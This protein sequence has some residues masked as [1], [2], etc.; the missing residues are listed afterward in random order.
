MFLSQSEVIRIIE[1]AIINKKILKVKYQHT[2]SDNEI[3]TSIKAPF[4]LGTTNTKTYY[5][6]KDN[7]Y[8]FCF[9]HI[10]EKTKQKLPIVHPISSL[11]IMSIAETGQKF[12][13]IELTDI[14]KANNK[15]D[16]R[17]CKWSLIPN[18]NWYK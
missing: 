11:H 4:D 15:Y 12:D 13:P 14:N 7:L 18:R 8:M 17:T 5:R 6:N 1:D 2:S 9:N 16:Y 3:I 10:D